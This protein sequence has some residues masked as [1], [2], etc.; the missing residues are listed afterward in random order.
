MNGPIK[1]AGTAAGL[2]RQD[3]V[4]TLLS[5]RMAKFACGKLGTRIAQALDVSAFE[6]VVDLL[7][8]INIQSSLHKVIREMFAKETGR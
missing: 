3:P 8:R 2:R 7:D 5:Y 1:V 4:S 6:Y